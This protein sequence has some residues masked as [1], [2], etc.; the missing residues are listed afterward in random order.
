MKM[1]R[2]YYNPHTFLL[3]VLKPNRENVGLLKF[4]YI[5][6]YQEYMNVLLVVPKTIELLLTHITGLSACTHNHEY[7]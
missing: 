4:P 3:R 1:K 5:Q 2:E 7:A 6:Y